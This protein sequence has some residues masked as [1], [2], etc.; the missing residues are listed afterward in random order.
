MT[1]SGSIFSPPYS[2]PAVQGTYLRYAPCLGL[3][4]VHCSLDVAGHQR[5]SG[6]G[7]YHRDGELALYCGA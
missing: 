3:G 6:Q 4:G 7:R 5:A 2:V 1:L